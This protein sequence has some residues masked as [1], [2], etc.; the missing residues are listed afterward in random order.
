MSVTPGLYRVLLIIVFESDSVWETEFERITVSVFSY[1][2]GAKKL[3]LNHENKDPQGEF[4]FAKLGRLAKE[5]VEAILPL[6]QEAL[7]SM[8]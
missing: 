8:D 4:R 5:E 7:K 3:Q 2:N 1:N 6:M